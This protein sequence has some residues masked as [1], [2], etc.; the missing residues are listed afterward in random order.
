MTSA[1]WGRM[2][3][4][5]CINIHSNFQTMLGQ[6]PMFLGCSEDVLSIVDGQCSG[7]SECS[8]RIHDHLSAITPCYPDLVRY[9]EASYS[10]VRGGYLNFCFIATYQGFVKKTAIDSVRTNYLHVLTKYQ[11][12]GKLRNF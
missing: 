12:K 3:A 6:D 10:C 1:R 9:L 7:R 8:F 5:R 11:A 2:K 4:G